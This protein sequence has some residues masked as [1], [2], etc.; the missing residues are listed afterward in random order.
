ETVGVAG[1]AAA[2]EPD[3]KAV[4]I[5]IDDRSREEREELAKNQTADDRK[6]EGAAQPG[7]GAVAERERERAEKSGHGWHENGTETQQARFVN[8]FDGSETV[9]RLG[10]NGKINH[11]NGIFLDD[12]DEK[13]D[14]N[15][16]DHGKFRFEKHQGEE[17][18][19]SRGRNRRKNGDG[20]DET[21]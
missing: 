18:A 9:L 16:G 13:N 4:H 10:L 12:T 8:S 19:N 5:E 11:E 1:R 7:P 20:M 14:A 2:T 3:L 17:R 6:A 21:L 15:I